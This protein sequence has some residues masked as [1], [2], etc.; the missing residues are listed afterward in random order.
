[1]DYEAHKDKLEKALEIKNPLTGMN[2]I[3]KI[4]KKL[5]W[6]NV[7][8]AL[9]E[10][11]IKIADELQDETKRYY[12]KDSYLMDPTT[13]KIAYVKTFE[14]L[15]KVTGKLD[16][17]VV[18]LRMANGDFYGFQRKLKYSEAPPTRLLSLALILC[19]ELGFLDASENH[20]MHEDA[21]GAK[22]RLIKAYEAGKTSHSNSKNAD[23]TTLMKI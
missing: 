19:Y 23:A 1:M 13:N 14:E 7:I 11:S 5:W 9:N 22:I 3:D 18:P 21:I 2:C 12:P 20:E 17:D 8:P 15:E 16:P 10:I 4:D 6:D